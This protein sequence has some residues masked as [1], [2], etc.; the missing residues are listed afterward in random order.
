M[1]HKWDHVAGFHWVDSTVFLY[2]PLVAFGVV[3]SLRLCQGISLTRFYLWI[4]LVAQGWSQ[5]G[6]ASFIAFRSTTRKFLES[7]DEFPWHARARCCCLTF[8]TSRM[9][10][11][12]TTKKVLANSNVIFSPFAGACRHAGCGKGPAVMPSRPSFAPKT[13]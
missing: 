13:K 5:S 1:A 10:L 12:F 9:S 2:F 8:G 11:K 7:L 4:M 3:A 6:F